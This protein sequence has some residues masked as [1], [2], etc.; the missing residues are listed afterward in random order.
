MSG[1][2]FVALGT[3]MAIRQALDVLQQIAEFVGEDG[4]GP[5]PVGAVAAVRAGVEA[6][7]TRLN[8]ARR[9]AWVAVKVEAT[10]VT[11]GDVVVA[12][13]G[14]L[15]EVTGADPVPGT[16]K[17]RLTFAG[18]DGGWSMPGD[19]PVPVLRRPT[20]DALDILTRQLGAQVTK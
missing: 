12:S 18:R 16:T 20:A 5:S 19:Y 2:D 1:L 7:E 6:L 10:T 11:I 17:I 15:M 4:D 14:V 13:D 8:T 9:T 3:G